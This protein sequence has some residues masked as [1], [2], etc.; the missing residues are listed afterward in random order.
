MWSQ[1][2]VGRLSALSRDINERIKESL[3]RKDQFGIICG[4]NCYHFSGI[5][6]QMYLLWAEHVNIKEHNRSEARVESNIPVLVETNGQMSIRNVFV[7]LEK[8]DN[9]LNI[10][11]VKLELQPELWCCDMDPRNIVTTSIHTV[12]NKEANA[13]VKAKVPDS[14]R[15]LKDEEQPFHSGW[16]SDKEEEQ[17]VIELQ[18]DSARVRDYDLKIEELK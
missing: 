9:P 17:E 6:G 11:N 10:T 2:Y 13:I 18:I 12:S 1:N 15:F 4:N 14:L 7:F 5:E 3:N 8:H 16:T